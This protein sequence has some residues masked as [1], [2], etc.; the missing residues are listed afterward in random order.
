MLSYEEFKAEFNEKLPRYMGSEYKDYGVKAQSV[1]KRG[2]ERD[3]FIFVHKDMEKMSGICIPTLYYDDIYEEYV[4]DEDIE[5]ELAY[6]A[7]TIDYAYEDQESMIECCSLEHMKDNVVFE[8]LNKEYVDTF[9][10]DYPQRPFMDMTI[11]YR[12]AIRVDRTGVYSG[13]INEESMKAAGLTEE[14]LY[15][16]ALAKTRD[17]I[18]YKVL[19]LEQVVRRTMNRE[20]ADIEKVEERL[21][22]V[23]E[24]EKVYFVTNNRSYRASTAMLYEDFLS[25][26]SEKI[27]DDFYIVPASVNDFVIVAATSKRESYDFFSMLIDINNTHIG[28]PDELL[29]WSIYYY[30]REKGQLEIY[31]KM[32]VDSIAEEE[33]K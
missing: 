15:N 17:L 16:I 11:V 6:I 12:W 28:S 21:E 22:S 26:I 32:D 13:L 20:G 23:F 7:Y 14:D 19:T 1:V 4:K 8:L 24:H 27:N 25:E 18:G 3:A 9:L 10:K 30:S 33:T 5:R 29:S 2:V 31:E